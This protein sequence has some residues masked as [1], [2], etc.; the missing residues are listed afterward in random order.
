LS[1]TCDLLGFNIC[2]PMGHNCC[3]YLE[4]GFFLDQYTKML[5]AGGCTKCESSLTHSLKPPGFNP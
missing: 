5:T 2:F 1:L 4:E 3:R